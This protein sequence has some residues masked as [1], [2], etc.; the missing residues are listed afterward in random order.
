MGA[1][2]THV[3]WDQ[4]HRGDP[5][6]AAIIVMA[7]AGAIVAMILQR[8]VIIVATA[9]GGAWTLLVGALAFNGDRNAARAALGGDVWILYPVA[10]AGQ[11]WVP[12]A[13]LGVGLVGTAV[14]LGLTGRRR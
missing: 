1:F 7:I 4:F 9:F 5:P 3:V 10:P 13:W 11:R 6:A 2:I 8:Y 12:I 14:Q